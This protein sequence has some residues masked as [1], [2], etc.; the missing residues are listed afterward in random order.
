MSVAWSKRT[1]LTAARNNL[2]KM[3]RLA[4]ITEAMRTN[5]TAVMEAV[6]DLAPLHIIVDRR[7]ETTTFRMI[8]DGTSKA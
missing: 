8:K 4:C 3:Q 5:P 6:L 7:P 1:N 2:Y